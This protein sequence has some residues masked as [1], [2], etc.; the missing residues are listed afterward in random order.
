MIRHFWLIWPE[1][2]V[3]MRLGFFILILL[4]SSCKSDQKICKCLEA[5]DKLNRLSAEL[6]EKEVTV[7]QKSEMKKLK[8]NQELLC[9]DFQEM[10][11]EEMLKRKAGCDLD[12][13][14]EAQNDEMLEIAK[15]MK[16]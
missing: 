11:G 13:A 12:D 1:K 16:K 5:G 9:K 2:L 14:T 15:Q 4:I 10:S 7:S 3:I 6:L 8:A